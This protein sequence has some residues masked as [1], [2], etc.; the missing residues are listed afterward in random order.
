MRNG[1][2]VGK[3]SFNRIDITEQISPSKT[4]IHTNFP[5]FISV[6]CLSLPVQTEQHYMETLDCMDV[7]CILV[8]NKWTP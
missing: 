4:G 6:V 7:F 3:T 2:H 5:R 1:V 8:Y